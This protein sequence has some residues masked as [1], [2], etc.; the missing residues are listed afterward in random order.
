MTLPF[1]ELGV[2]FQALGLDLDRQRPELRRLDR[3]DALQDGK[4][5]AG[6]HVQDAAH[7][8]HELRRVKLRHR[9]DVGG[10]HLFQ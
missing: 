2:L 1:V 7:E 4:D 10:A 8:G 3:H 5:G 9:L 6:N